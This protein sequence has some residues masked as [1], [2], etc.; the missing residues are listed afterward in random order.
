[1]Q[2]PQIDPSVI[3]WTTGIVA[4]ITALARLVSV[5]W[6]GSIS[7]DQARI[8]N[9]WKRM[10]DHIDDLRSDNDRLRKQLQECY[11]EINR[12]RKSAEEA[13]AIVHRRQNNRKT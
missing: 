4:A 7:H 2:A 6:K 5:Y 10:D 9:Q 1:M 3:A 8:A 11:D 13:W 12:L